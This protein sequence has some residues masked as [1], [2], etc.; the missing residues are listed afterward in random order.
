MLGDTERARAGRAIDALAAA[1]IDA[2]VA[3]YHPE[4]EFVMTEGAGPE[5]GTTR[6]AQAA[7]SQL[8]D[9]YA[10]LSRFVI[11]VVDTVEAKDSVLCLARFSGAGATSGATVSEPWAWL[12]SFRDGM[13]SRVEVYADWDEARHAAGLEAR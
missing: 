2:L 13:I 9:I 3:E 12:W 4:V 6:G 8:R 11:E 5:P 7:R 1:D 10:V